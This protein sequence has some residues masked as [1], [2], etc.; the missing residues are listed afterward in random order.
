MNP[1]TPWRFRATGTP[2]AGPLGG[3]AFLIILVL[4][5]ALALA[6]F[7][8]AI[9]VLLPVAVVAMLYLWLRSLAR[10]IRGTITGA[11]PEGRRNVRVIH[12]NPTHDPTHD[13]THNPTDRPT[14]TP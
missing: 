7:I 5:A 2:F 10:S 4:G 13:P 6:L 12:H 11:D 1:P 8:L 14:G 3:L 9:A